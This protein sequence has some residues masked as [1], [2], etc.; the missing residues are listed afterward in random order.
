MPLHPDGKAR[1]LLQL[2]RIARGEHVGVVDIG[3][4]TPGQFD[5]L[6]RQKREAGLAEPGSPGLVYKGKHHYNSRVTEDGYEI[7]DLVLQIESALAVDSIVVT[8]GRSMTALVCAH[9]RD[10][11]Y[12][13][14]VRDRAILE[15]TARKPKGE[16]FSAIP[17]GD[18]P[19]KTQ[20]AA[21][22][23]RP[24]AVDRSTPRITEAP[25]AVECVASPRITVA[26][27]GAG[28]VGD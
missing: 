14:R 27:G 8:K 12:G 17:K 15:L 19:P 16:V 4:L 9:L 23:G 21:L 11:G 26:A 3:E 20:K 13:G 5:D 18:V 10:D 22:A 28:D 2:Q 24:S 7:K 6:R 1:I 25:A